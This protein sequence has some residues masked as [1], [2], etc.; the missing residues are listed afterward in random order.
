MREGSGEVFSEFLDSS[1][2]VGMDCLFADVEFTGDLGLC[3]V[4]EHELDHLVF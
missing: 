3:V 4:L 2:F 1:F